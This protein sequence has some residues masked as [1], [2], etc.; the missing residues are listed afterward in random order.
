MAY[1]HSGGWHEDQYEEGSPMSRSQISDVF[2]YDPYIGFQAIRGEENL[3][4]SFTW[5][6][7]ENNNPGET[8]LYIPQGTVLSTLKLY[9]EVDTSAS[10]FDSSSPPGFGPKY[11]RNSGDDT[12]LYFGGQ[13]GGSTTGTTYVWQQ[14]KHDEGEYDNVDSDCY[15]KY[16]YKH[17]KML[18]IFSLEFRFMNPAT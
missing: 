1:V 5:D 9:M 4:P 10:W 13:F 14:D 8:W 3:D 16:D 17:P 6:Y 7:A 15:V 12:N 18:W 11:S 2:I